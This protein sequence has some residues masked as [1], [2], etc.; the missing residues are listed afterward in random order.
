MTSLEDFEYAQ[1]FTGITAQQVNKA[2][3]RVQSQWYGLLN[4]DLWAGLPQPVQAGKIDQITDLLVAWYLAQN[5]PD[6]VVNAVANGALPLSSKSIDG[7]SV[8]YMPLENVQGDMKML[9]TNQWGVQALQMFQ[10]APERYL[11]FPGG[12]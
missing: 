4:G 1:N 8:N 6:S 9:L 11:L 2:L 3:L 7:V 12:V 10:S 5:Y